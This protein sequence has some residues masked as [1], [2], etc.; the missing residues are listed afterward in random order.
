MLIH[1]C[2]GKILKVVISFSPSMPIPPP[3]THHLLLLNS[4]IGFDSGDNLPTLD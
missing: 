3:P 2:P 4:D 1:F